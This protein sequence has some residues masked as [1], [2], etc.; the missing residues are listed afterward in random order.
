MSL[1]G[2]VD[3][4]CECGVGLFQPVYKLAWHEQHGTTQKPE[5]WTC[6][7]CGKR[8][9]NNAMIR[10]VKTRNLSEK[11]RELEEQL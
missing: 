5:G 10:R 7:G 11:I 9:D 2:W 1:Q 4:Y 3:M 8:S 6:I